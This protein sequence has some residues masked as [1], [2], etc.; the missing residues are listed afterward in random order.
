MT[1]IS[2]YIHIPFCIRKCL[3]CDF[4]SAPAGK[5]LQERYFRA[6]LSEIRGAAPLYDTYEVKTVFIGG[7]TPSAADAG[8]ISM[9]VEAVRSGFHVSENPEITMEMNPGTETPGKLRIY[10]EAGI[11]RLSIGCQSL[12]DKELKALGR[13]HD[14]AAFY[15]CYEDA[16]A[17]GF[18]NINID[19]MSALP[20]QTPDGWRDTLEKTM[21]LRPE[22][23][24]AYS[25]MIE[26]GTP[27]YDRYG[28]VSRHDL[29]DDLEKDDSQRLKEA[30]WEALPSEEAERQ[31]YSDTLRILKNAGY[32]RYEISNYA[33]DCI[34]DPGKYECHHNRVYWE[35]GNYLGF[36]IGAASLVE[37]T[38]WSN[39]REL[40]RYI[41]ENG[42][43]EK[44]RENKEQ[45]T[46]HAQMEEFMFLGLRLT[47]G[48]SMRGFETY[49]GFPIEKIYGRVIRKLTEEGLLEQKAD[50][51]RLTARG[52]DVSN[53]A[54]AEF[55]FD[56]A[57]S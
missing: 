52:T 31:M 50:H 47:E 43:Q 17:A 55:L 21:A 14:S 11:N 37:N 46:V 44:I 49:F 10:S 32:H 22:H 45:L 39:T 7:G 48:V 28:D 54:M 53:Y 5:D 18:R 57:D 25:L 29:Y 33:R 6:L 4:L 16:R 27:F 51:L 26:E 40:N 1:P 42:D 3:Y 34:T 13:I 23:I 9:L 56:E 15:R 30:K 12:Q 2:V 20:G 35:R 41:A 38:R 36:G 24:S 8:W 19:L